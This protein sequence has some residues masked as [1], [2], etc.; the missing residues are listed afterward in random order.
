SSL[1]SAFTFAAQPPACVLKVLIVVDDAAANT[2]LSSLT[3]GIDENLL[4]RLAT[5]VLSFVAVC[6]AAPTN[7][8]RASR[9]P[10]SAPALT[11]ATASFVRQLTALPASSLVSA[12]IFAGQPLACVLKV[13]MVVSEADANTEPSSLTPG[14]DENLLARLATAV[15][16]FVAV[17]AAAPM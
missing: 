1:V 14:I 6:A 13:L 5:A 8:G 7:S 16:S 4:A 11:A 2:E 3:P 10:A 17:C 12:L 9:T 15:L